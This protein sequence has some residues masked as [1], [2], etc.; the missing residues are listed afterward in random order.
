MK[1]FILGLALAPMALFASGAET[2]YDI[3][4]RTV[5]FVIF[6]A[7]LWYLL[8]DKIKAAFADRSLSIQA[9][10][11]KVQD[12]LDASAK[13][14]DNAAAKLEEAKKLAIEVVDGANAEIEK[15]KQNVLAAVESDIANLEKHFDEKV[16]V[17]ARKAKKEVV[18]EI[19]DELLSTDNISLSQEELSNIV[20]K[21]V[22]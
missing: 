6:A 16:K 8:A 17:E 14:V 13:K 11:D 10:L 21:K 20:L 19:L 2:D 1:K 5:N 7:I 3:I 12:T 18:S 4:Q 9:E 22:A 15:I